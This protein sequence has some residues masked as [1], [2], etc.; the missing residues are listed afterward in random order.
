MALSPR[1]LL[2]DEL[3]LDAGFAALVFG[4][5][6]MALALGGARP[7]PLLATAPICIFG[8]VLVLSTSRRSKLPLPS[9][10]A[11][12]LAGYTLLQALPLPVGFLSW[13]SPNA[14][15]IWSRALYP[16]GEPVNTGA[17]SLDPGASLREA[18][19]WFLYGTVFAA[20]RVVTRRRG[21]Y[22]C[23]L[24]V[25]ACALI[26][27]VVTLGHGLV[28]ARELFGVY[29]PTFKTGRWQ[30][31]PLLNPNNLSSFL[32]VGAFVGLGL[33]FSVRMGRFR[34]FIAVGVAL[35]LGVSILTGSRAGLALVPVG[36]VLFV[37]LMRAGYARGASRS[38]ARRWLPL[39]V[40]SGSGAVFAMLGARQSTWDELFSSNLEK[41]ALAADVVPAIGDFFVFG[42]G[43]GAFET[44]FPAYAPPGGNV[45]YSHP[46]NLLVQWACEWG[47]PVSAVAILG[48]VWAFR[49]RNVKVLGSAVGA[50]AATA[51]VVLI[52]HNLV[53]LGSETP[54]IPL[55][56]SWALAVIWAPP[57]GS[58]RL[59]TTERPSRAIARHWQL[60]ALA[61]VSV[62][63]VAV[64][65]GRSSVFD[66]RSMRYDPFVGGKTKELSIRAFHQGLRT[67]MLR[68]PAE[69]YFPRLGAGVAIAMHDRAT[70]RWIQRALE[71]SPN[72]GRTHLLVA[73]AL[74]QRGAVKQ[75]LLE[76]R[77]AAESDETLA[78]STGKLAAAWSGSWNELQRAVPGGRHGALMLT[79]ASRELTHDTKLCLR[80][81]R[82]AVR[83][84]PADA[85][86]R[87]ALVQGLIRGLE[88]GDCEIGSC[89]QE[90]LDQLRILEEQLP[91]RATPVVLHA[92][93]LVSV[94]R[95]PEARTL[96][97]NTC[98]SLAAKESISCLS[99]ALSISRAVPGSSSW[100]AEA[101]HHLFERCRASGRCVSELI[102]VGDVYAGLGNWPRALAAYESATDERASITALSKL[103]H[104]ASELGRYAQADAALVR[105]QRLAAGDAKTLA[106]LKQRQADLR[107]RTL[108]RGL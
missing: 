2:D 78:R 98:S 50:G 20:A 62:W 79:A 32:N 22:A 104:A 25:Y 49:P 59:R 28:R 83:I 52:L 36:L 72:D 6:A 16:L 71:R 13:V 21:T 102:R 42:M 67:S 12:A 87:A 66:E 55:I 53:D 107:Q 26:V 18:L 85:E 100:T 5:I 56:A 30:V 40:A 63:V 94:K 65:L 64:W 82:E 17:L 51:V 88:R 103:A 39:A 84:D 60:V 3:R 108:S 77:L 69:P 93:L 15:D 35:L 1:W 97:N 86:A 9:T 80:S 33:A 43:R 44:V 38:T 101:A 14:A 74:Q 89:E 73:R 57:Q 58:E 24:V 47:V 76:L 34:W 8:A 10:I 23:A 29:E 7:V 90:A 106:Q 27:A 75:A 61:G 19:K 105:A 11:F 99:S 81:L 37:V 54:A 70:M 45:I 68:Y 48:V 46:E 41:L 95:W 4:T 31:A 91:K 96:L 92:R